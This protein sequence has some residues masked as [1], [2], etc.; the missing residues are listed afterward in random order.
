VE[1][2]SERELAVTQLEGFDSPLPPICLLNASAVLDV[3][4]IVGIW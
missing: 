2:R 1:V 4:G 3:F